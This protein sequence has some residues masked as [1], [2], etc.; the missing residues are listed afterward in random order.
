MAAKPM[1]EQKLQLVTRT[2]NLGQRQTW[3]EIRS[4]VIAALAL[5][6]AIVV[7]SALSRL[8]ILS[9]EAL[10]GGPFWHLPVSVWVGIALLAAAA[11]AL[12]SDRYRVVAV[13]AF[14]LATMGALGYLEPLGVFHDSW[15]NV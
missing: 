3:R 10:I 11:L 1:I 13:A 8:P 6:V 9:P 14:G 15:R 12:D 4:A 5:I 7:L 2:Q